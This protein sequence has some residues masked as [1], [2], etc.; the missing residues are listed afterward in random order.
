MACSKR[1][2]PTFE[3]ARRR[4]RCAAAILAKLRNELIWE[5]AMVSTTRCPV[6]ALCELA[7]AARGAKPRRAARWGPS[8]VVHRVADLVPREGACPQNEA[9]GS[10]RI[11]NLV[12]SYL[13]LL[14]IPRTSAS[15]GNVHKCIA[16]WK[17]PRRAAQPRFG[18]GRD[19]AGTFG[20]T[21]SGKNNNEINFP[22]MPPRY[23]FTPT[24]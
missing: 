6:D 3:I 22:D 8:T 11:N 9:K 14:P 7:G 18:G 16:R 21:I 20:K 2:S 24:P 4:G 10:N 15:R 12:V 17:G 23:R 1:W 19:E 5:I 13:T